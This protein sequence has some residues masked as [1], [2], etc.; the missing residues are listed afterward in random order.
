MG[1][2]GPDS[3]LRGVPGLF[4]GG[5]IQ[6]IPEA[7]PSGLGASC[8]QCPVG[9]FAQVCLGGRGP[10]IT[11]EAVEDFGVGRVVAI[12][13]Q[14]VALLLGRAK[15]FQ[16]G[17]WLAEEMEIERPNR[18][19]E[20]TLVSPRHNLRDGKSLGRHP[21]NE[22]SDDAGRAGGHRI[23]F[24]IGI[25]GFHVW[26]RAS[27]E[28]RLDGEG[29]SVFV[30]SPLPGKCS[31]LLSD[32]RI[33]MV[34]VHFF[35]QASEKRFGLRGVEASV[36]VGLLDAPEEIMGVLVGQPVNQFPG[37]KEPPVVQVMVD[38][39]HL[40]LEEKNSLNLVDLMVAMEVMEDQ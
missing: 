24:E 15:G 29:K 10:G 12:F 13:L 36:D 22:G 26:Q 38:Q 6:Q 9:E 35:L 40:V 1:P 11:A 14:L 7:P 21:V 2:R 20:P 3:H 30:P 37:F 28:E 25:I 32:D 34:E 18:V 39:D 17:R 31:P 23:P 27:L 19:G 4:V 5:V 33:G 8:E 16:V